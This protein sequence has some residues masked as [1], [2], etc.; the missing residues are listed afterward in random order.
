MIGTLGI[1]MAAK[2]EGKITSAKNAVKELIL[3]G[4]FLDQNLVKT[5]LKEYV[6]EDWEII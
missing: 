1:I 5:I 2:K 6:N 4:L 3:S